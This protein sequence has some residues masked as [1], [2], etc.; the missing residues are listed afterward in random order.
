MTG[1]LSTLQ[2]ERV[3][4]MMPTWL[5]D[6]VMATPALRVLRRRFASAKLSMLLPA[7]MAPVFEPCPLVDQRLVWSKRDGVARTGRRLRPERF[8]LAVVLPGS[9]RS[10]LLAWLAGAK[11]R[12]GYRRDKRGWLLTDRLDPPRS[13]GRR[14]RFT[15]VPTLRYYLDLVKATGAEIRD[16]D[17]A[18]K[19]WVHREDEARAWARLG[20]AGI[21]LDGRPLA[22]LVPG[23]NRPEKRWPPERFAALADHL[24]AAHGA[25]VAVSGSPAEAAV[26]EA[27]T[28][29]AGCDVANLLEAGID[30]RL[31]KSVFALAKLVVTNDTGPRHVAVAMGTPVVS[32]FGPTPLPWTVLDCTHEITLVAPDSHDAAGNLKPEG[33]TIT[34]IAL[35]D[36]KQAA[37]ALLARG[38]PA[39]APGAAAS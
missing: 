5:G 15:P 37:D 35:D 32:L 4:V 11:R 30:L 9:F 24:H 16:E 10:A 7:A 36:V 28:D 12:L 6:C 18:M 22:V 31:L 20:E 26:L 39:R 21:E 34:A 14:G 3:L 13:G 25:T 38:G 27:V 8:D 17:K 29:R 2:P 23:G 19:L 33:G 1:E